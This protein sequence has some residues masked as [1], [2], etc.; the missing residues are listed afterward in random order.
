MFCRDRLKSNSFMSRLSHY[1]AKTSAGVKS[2]P[3]ATNKA[4]NEKEPDLG[5]VV[6]GSFG[7]P[8]GSKKSSLSD[9]EA[10]PMNEAIGQ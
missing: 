5:S 7:S 6:H 10:M 2:E 4:G 1:S 9:K 8:H 3:A